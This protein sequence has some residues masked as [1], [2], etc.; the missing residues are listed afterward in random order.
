MDF[1]TVILMVILKK[2]LQLRVHQKSQ[3]K[4]HHHNLLV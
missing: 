2:N 3:C 4:N 1:L